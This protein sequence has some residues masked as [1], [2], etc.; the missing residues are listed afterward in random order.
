VL[1][2]QDFNANNLASL[3]LTVGAPTVMGQIIVNVVGGDKANQE[4]VL[5][6]VAGAGVAVV[7]MIAAGALPAV[8]DMETLTLVGTISAGIYVGELIG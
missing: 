1:S 5:S 8:V 2:G 3:L 7:L 4:P 6:A